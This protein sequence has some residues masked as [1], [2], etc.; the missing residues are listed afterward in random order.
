MMPN[1]QENEED[2]DNEQQPLIESDSK[3]CPILD[4]FQDVSQKHDLWSTHCVLL[5]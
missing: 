1:I 5:R 4:D 2:H 3:T